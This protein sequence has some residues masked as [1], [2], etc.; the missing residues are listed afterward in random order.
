[1]AWLGLAIGS[2]TGLRIIRTL[3]HI[4]QVQYVKPHENHIILLTLSPVT[5]K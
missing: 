4:R 1:M 2:K 5:S 3:R